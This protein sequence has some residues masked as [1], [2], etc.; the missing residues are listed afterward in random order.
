MNQADTNTA[1]AL[2]GGYRLMNFA[3]LA[4]GQGH[5]V[6][7]PDGRRIAVVFSKDD[8]ELILGSLNRWRWPGIE[9]SDPPVNLVGAW[10][11]AIERAIERGAHA[12]SPA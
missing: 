10:N 9:V 8:A 6:I 3:G 11:R 5:A 4:A 2:P 7:G 12:L 1:P